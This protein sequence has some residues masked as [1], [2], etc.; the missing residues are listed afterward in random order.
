MDTLPAFK[1]PLHDQR[2]DQ[3]CCARIYRRAIY[4]TLLTLKPKHSFEIGTFTFQSSSVWSRFYEEHLQEGKLITADI[5]MWNRGEPPKH[6]YPVMFYPYEEDP[7]IEHGSMNVY[8]KNYREVAQREL[9]LEL[10]T[11]KLFESM[12]EHNIRSFD[13]TFVD[14]S[15]S[16]KSFLSDLYLAQLTTK[17]DG[18]ILIDDIYPTPGGETYEQH[19]V[20]QQLK[21]H[22]KFYEYDDWNPNPILAL[23]QNKELIV[24]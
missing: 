18:W 4:N 7:S 16:A 10:N 22:N 8:Y 11:A 15:H 24:K 20:Y 9:S 17:P 2:T 6:V 21:R 19:V 1:I 13:L 14:G 5:T 3:D 12:T 23:I